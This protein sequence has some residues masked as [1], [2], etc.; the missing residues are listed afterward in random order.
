MIFFPYNVQMIH[1]L[2]ATYIIY[3]VKIILNPIDLMVT[4]CT[5]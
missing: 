4:E 3:F 1:H 5:V 2:S